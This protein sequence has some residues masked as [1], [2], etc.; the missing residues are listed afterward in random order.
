MLEGDLKLIPL[1]LI[2]LWKAG[3]LPLS[4]SLLF[5]ILFFFPYMSFLPL[6]FFRMI[7]SLF[8]QDPNFRGRRVV[9]FH[10]QRDY[11]FF[12]HHRCAY[13]NAIRNRGF[14]WRVMFWLYAGCL[15]VCLVICCLPFM[16]NSLWKWL[17]FS[18][19]K[20]AIAMLIGKADFCGMTFVVSAC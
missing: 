7:Q 3:L 6:S 11:I 15:G 2:Y 4:S 20:F 18:K 9:T 5:W 8:P 16:N 17:I 12:R 13:Q 14:V 1:F 10:N 19:H